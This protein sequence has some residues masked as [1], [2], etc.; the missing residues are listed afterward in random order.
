MFNIIAMR[1]GE[2]AT[3]EKMEEDLVAQNDFVG[4]WIEAVALPQ[5]GLYL[6][7]NEQGKLMGLPPN[8]YMS[9]DD[10]KISKLPKEN[11]TY[12]LIVGNIFITRIGNWGE[13]VSVTMQDFLQ[14]ED[15]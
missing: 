15:C 14:Y 10:R 3:L 1:I 2:P 8:R 5:P 7:C 6:I 11:V 12:D 4:G 13:N 9:I